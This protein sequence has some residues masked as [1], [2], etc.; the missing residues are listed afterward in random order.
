MEPRIAELLVRGG[1]VTRE[2]LDK[3][4]E[5][6]KKN[7]ANLSQELV[8]LGFTTEHHL[9]E[10]LAK[11]FG[12][13]S[14]DLENLEVQDAIFSLVPPA[15]IQ[16]HQLIPLKLVGS[17]LTVAMSDPTNLVAINEVKFI[18]GYGVRVVLAG[19]SSIIKLLKKRYGT[20]SYDEVL[21]KLDDNEMEVIQ[22]E[23]EV[24]LQELQKSTMEA[25]VVTLVNAILA[26]AAKRSAS[27]IHIEPYEKVFRIRF[28]V[29]G[30]LH[31]IMSPPLRLRNPMISRIKVMAG[32]DIAE[33]R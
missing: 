1:I 10:F 6:E 19:A 3:A 23:E 15:L 31:D 14:V 8:R 5:S 29:D 9:T 33:R 25:P 21:R 20:V 2:Q 26:D 17:S 22:E 4:L 27:D 18:T 30:V 12:I 11:Q 13:E 24:D 7:G 16:K 28:R 32:L